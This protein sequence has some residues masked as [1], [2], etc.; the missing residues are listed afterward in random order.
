MAKKANAESEHH[1]EEMQ[2]LVKEFLKRTRLSIKNAQLNEYDGNKVD[3]TKDWFSKELTIQVKDLRTRF[4][5]L[6]F[7]VNH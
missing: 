7:N 4:G 5:H 1:H 6:F 2:M 3:D